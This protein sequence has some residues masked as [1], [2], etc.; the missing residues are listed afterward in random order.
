MINKF[1]GDARAGARAGRADR[2]G[3]ACRS[4]A[5]CPG[6]ADSGWTARTPSRSGGWR[7][8]DGSAERDLRVAV[9]R[10]PRISNVTDVDALAAEPGVDVLVTTDPASSPSADLVVLPGSRSTVARPRLAARQRPG[11]GAGST[12]RRG[13]RRCSG[14][15]GGYQML[16]ATIDDEVESRRRPRRR[17][18]AC[19]RPRS[20]SPPTRCS[21]GRPDAGAGHRVRAYEIHHGIAAVDAATPSRSWT[22]A[23]SGRSGARCGTARFENDDFRRAWLAEVAARPAVGLAPG[24]GRARLRGAAGDDDRHPG[25]R[26]RGAC[27]PRPAAGRYPVGSADDR[28][29]SW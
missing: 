10:L 1:R 22:A 15:C 4:P 7:R 6:C 8:I 24:A 2:R 3:P 13:G 28:S 20:T 11:R 19:C 21:A 14:I 26:D 5:C 25:R 12:G 17:A 16:A 29:G 9:V 27:R 23:G 18:S